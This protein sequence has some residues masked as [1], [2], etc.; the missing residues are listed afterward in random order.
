VVNQGRKCEC[1]TKTCIK[2]ATEKIHY[3][4]QHVWKYQITRLECVYC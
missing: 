1:T 4:K 3:Y 2:T